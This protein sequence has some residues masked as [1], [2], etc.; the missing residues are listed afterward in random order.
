MQTRS[1][2]ELEA[3]TAAA[4]QPSASTSGTVK[5]TAEQDVITR[6]AVGDDTT[7]VLGLDN[8]QWRPN[9]DIIRAVQAL[10][11]ACASTQQPL[12]PTFSGAEDEDPA[13]FFEG[14]ERY[15]IEARVPAPRQL[16][17]TIGQLRHTAAD[18]VKPFQN[19][20]LTYDELKDVITRQFSG[21]GVLAV[22]FTRL[23]SQTQPASEPVEI[24]LR[25]KILLFHRLRP[26]AAFSEIAAILIELVQ[27]RL[28]SFLRM[29]ASSDIDTFLAQA[30][31]IERDQ[32]ALEPPK[33]PPPPPQPP[34][35]PVAPRLPRCYHCPG[36]HYNYDCP[37]RRSGNEPGTGV[38]PPPPPFDRS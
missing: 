12:A 13:A 31:G 25:K 22:L 4:G 26:G 20:R 3:E 38:L 17:T 29:S 18:H 28:R 9:T 6:P 35:A 10:I 11:E 34:R 1:Q 15:F 30:A 21:P 16:D 33:R 5:A 37:T 27:P 24:F 19:L 36:R 2:A 7:P 32:K 8:T 14:L 23:Y